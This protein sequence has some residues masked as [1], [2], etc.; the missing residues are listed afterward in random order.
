MSE[1]F[2]RLID[3]VYRYP[4]QQA[5]T[6]TINRQ[7]RSGSSNEQ[8]VDLAQ[9]LRAENKLSIIHD[10]ADAQAEPQIVCSLGLV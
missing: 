5:A 7:L 10:Q 2:N 6:D 1:E 3:D 8:L 4:L 9:G